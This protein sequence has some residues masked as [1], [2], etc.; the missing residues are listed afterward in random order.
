MSGAYCD[1]STVL[2][3]F[4]FPNQQAN[5][6]RLKNPANKIHPSV[7]SCVESFKKHVSLIQPA[8]V[9]ASLV[10]LLI[11]HGEWSGLHLIKVALIA[12]TWVLKPWL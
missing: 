11:N 10:V 3:F 2:G 8:A 4:F 12:E 7:I 9:P 5:Y 1:K 6:P